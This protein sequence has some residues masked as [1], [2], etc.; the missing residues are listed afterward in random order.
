MLSGFIIDAYPPED[1]EFLISK[2]VGETVEN[3][4]C[5]QNLCLKL[6]LIGQTPWAVFILNIR[7]NM[8]F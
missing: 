2:W 3:L 8:D 1:A 6:L 7:I 5:T 4:G